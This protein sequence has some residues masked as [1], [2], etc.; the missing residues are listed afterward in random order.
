MRANARLFLVFGFLICF[1][2]T[3]SQLN[4]NFGMDRQGGC[5]PLQVSFTNFSSGLSSNAKFSWDLGNGN[6]STL[7]HPSAIYNEEKTYTI[8]LTVQDGTQSSTI[9]KTITVYKKPVADFIV[10]SPKVCLPASVQFTSSSTPGDGSINNYQWDFGDGTT[11]QGF[12]NQMS[13]Y[14]SY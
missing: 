13:H 8:T 4:A 11:Q 12:G 3:W 5:S 10:A 1:T 6:A 7:Q 2:P 9:S 14:Y